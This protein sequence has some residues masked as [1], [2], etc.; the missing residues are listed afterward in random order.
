MIMYQKFLSAGL[1]LCLLPIT[2]HTELI[3]IEGDGYAY[4]V[5]ESDQ[6]QLIARKT[7]EYLNRKNI[8]LVT[9][10]K[11]IVKLVNPPKPARKERSRR[12]DVTYTYTKDVADKDGNIV[13]GAGDKY[14]PLTSLVMPSLIVVS[15]RSEAQLLWATKFKEENLSPTSMIILSDGNWVN[16]RKKYGI[17]AYRLSDRLQ[18]RLQITH[19]PCT[20]MQDGSEVVIHEYNMEDIE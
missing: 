13:R 16:V 10:E 20:V 17:E 6:T 4:D 7:G 8:P 18:K 15:G 19:V 2:A 5:I 9:G 3:I 12:V 1:L 11:G 14:N